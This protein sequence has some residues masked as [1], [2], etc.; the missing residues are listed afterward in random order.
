MVKWKQNGGRMMTKWR[1]KDGNSAIKKLEYCD[2][3]V[4][5]DNGD[6]EMH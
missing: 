2:D 6:D 5:R 1:Q 3:D 4:K